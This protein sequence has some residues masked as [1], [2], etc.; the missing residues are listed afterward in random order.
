MTDINDGTAQLISP[1]VAGISP[2]IVRSKVD[3]P[4]RLTGQTAISPTLVGVISC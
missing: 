3:F 1:P 4:V 2:A